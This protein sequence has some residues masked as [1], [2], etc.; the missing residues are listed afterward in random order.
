[1]ITVFSL[2]NLAPDA[3]HHMSRVS[4][5]VLGLSSWERKTV[6]LSANRDRMSLCWIFG[7]FMFSPVSLSIVLKRWDMGSIV[8]LNNRDDRGSPWQTS[9]VMG[10]FLLFSPLRITAVLAL[11]YRDLMVFMRFLGM[12]I[13]CRTFHR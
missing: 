5:S 6:A 3:W 13:S 8:K 10:K 12:F 7:V 4:N 2:L 9:L 1:M 11:V